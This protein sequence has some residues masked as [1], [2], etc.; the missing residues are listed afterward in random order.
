[1]VRTQP[2]PRPQPQIEEEK[3]GSVEL[4]LF[5]IP[6][7]LSSDS[8]LESVKEIESEESHKS[9]DVISEHSNEEDRV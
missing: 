3:K 2:K 1:M 6:A 5:D 8:E 4:D 7:Y 9:L